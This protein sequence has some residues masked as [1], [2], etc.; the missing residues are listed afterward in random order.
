M[1]LVAAAVVALAA[2][3]LAAD[4]A[5]PRARAIG[6]DAADIAGFAAPVSADSSVSLVAARIPV[7]PFDASTQ[8]PVAR[9][10]GTPTVTTARGPERRLT[11]ILIADNRPVAV[12]NDKVVEVGALLPDGARV[13]SIQADR[14]WVVEKT[15]KWRMLTL[16]AG[17]P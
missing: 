1:I 8:I 11:A 13:S 12:I 7:D 4:P 14:V 15:G 2:D 6:N 17:T 16:S 5:G 3:R 9:L 10:D